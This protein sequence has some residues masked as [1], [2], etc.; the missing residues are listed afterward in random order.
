MNINLKV[1]IALTAWV[2]AVTPPVLVMSRAARAEIE[3][4]TKS[5]PVTYCDGGRMTLAEAAALSKKALQSRYCGSVTG[6][7]QWQALIN[8]S[9]Y[10][11][12]KDMVEHDKCTAAADN[13]KRLYKERFDQEPGKCK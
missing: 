2:G 13:I 10:V 5:F 7:R 12:D 4:S 3:P 8:S 1:G 9:R 11:T 6:V